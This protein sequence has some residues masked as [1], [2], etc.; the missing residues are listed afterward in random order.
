[1][2]A[3]IA[4]PPTR[5][6]WTPM[7]IGLAAAAAEM[8][9]GGRRGAIVTLDDVPTDEALASRGRPDEIA[10]SESQSRF[11]LEVP[12]EREEDLLANLH[13]VPCAKVGFVTDDDRFVMQW[14]GNKLLDLGADALARAWKQ[15]LDL[16][17]DLVVEN[18]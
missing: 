9:I 5:S 13:G 1:M 2:H 4:D 18:A 11:L 7:A 14:R 3:T 6:M 17:G 10:F 15:P 12:P 8:C 16:D